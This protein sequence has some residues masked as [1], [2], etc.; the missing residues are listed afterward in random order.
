MRLKLPAKDKRVKILRFMVNEAEYKALVKGQ[1]KANFR[2][3]S[4]YIRTTMVKANN[5]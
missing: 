4:E 5:G 3:L 1:K 2:F